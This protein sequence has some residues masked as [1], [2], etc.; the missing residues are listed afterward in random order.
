MKRYSLGVIGCGN[1]AKAILRALN[2]ETV[3]YLMKQNGI[4]ISL[5]V[6]DTDAEKFIDL[7]CREITTYTDNALLVEASDI[8]LLAVKPQAAQ[9]ALNGI[10][11]SG[12]LVMSIMAGVTLKRL[13]SLMTTPADRLVRIMPNLNARY[14]CSVNAYCGEGLNDSDEEVVL[15]ILGAF[16]RAY[17]VDECF[18]NSITGISGSGP[19]F[20]FMFIDAFIQKAIS[21]GFKADVSKELVLDTIYGCLE[22][23]RNY[24]GN[25]G[26]LIDS[27]CSKG[28]TTIEGV[29][30]LKANNFEDLVKQAITKSEK[31]SEE[32]EKDI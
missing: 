6:S 26:E 30:H 16:G 14:G 29:N 12:K 15:N 19:A 24:E 28:G 23:V 8:V 3:I 17:K 27:V 25:I 32:L 11:F 4:R 31:R 20:A 22:N 9:A 21:C 10:D 5:S 18:M 7:N 2:S 13:K 1:M